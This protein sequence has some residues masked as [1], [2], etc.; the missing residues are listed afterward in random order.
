MKK[1]RGRICEQGGN[2]DASTDMTRKDEFVWE[3]AFKVT[4]QRV[5]QED[6]LVLRRSK[7]DTSAW[8]ERRRTLTRSGSEVRRGH[9]GVATS[10]QKEVV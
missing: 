8:K 9:F 6:S 7:R 1:N 4:S 10:K 5:V 2:C 3:G